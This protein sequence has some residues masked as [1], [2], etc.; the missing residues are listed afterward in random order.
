M[1]PRPEPDG[2]NASRFPDPLLAGP[3]GLVAMG[4]RLDPDWL[5][6]AYRHGVFPW[7]SRDDEPMLWWSPD[8]RALMPLEGLRVSRRLQRTIRSER[9]EVACDTDFAGVL[10]GCA[11]GPGR[12]GGTWITDGMRDAYQEMHR[13]GHAH[14]VEAR[15]EGRLVGGVYGLAIGGLFAAESMFH[16][17][18]D[19]SKVALAA[20]VSH[21]NARGYRLLDIQ[22]WTRHTGSLGA[23]E[24]SR[25][26]Y[27]ERLAEAVEA[28]VTFG[29]HLAAE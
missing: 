11:T 15:R 7:P 8:P 24:V 20:L 12:E 26:D 25:S 27:L 6:D 28:P 16:Y 10:E 13:L 19:A 9:F 17:E 23:V 2:P 14:S 1:T 4:G 18:T 22:Q 5:L 21:L 3:E 29:D